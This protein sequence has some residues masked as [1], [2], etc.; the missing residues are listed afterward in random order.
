MPASPAVVRT[1]FPLAIPW[2]E[3]KRRIEAG[4]DP[5]GLTRAFDAL[6][7]TTKGA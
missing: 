6:L 2:A 1:S 3:I 5:A 7:R 4:L